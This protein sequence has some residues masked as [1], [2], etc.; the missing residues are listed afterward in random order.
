MLG[1]NAVAFYNLDAAGLMEV[2]SR[3][4]PPKAGFAA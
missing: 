1:G 4:G 3:V 2:A